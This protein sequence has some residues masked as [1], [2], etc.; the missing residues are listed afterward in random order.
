VDTATIVARRATGEWLVSWR[1]DR[2]H[3]APDAIEQS[4]C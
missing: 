2:V 4:I 3:S 1:V